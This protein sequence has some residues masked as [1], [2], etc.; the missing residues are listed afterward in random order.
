MGFRQ[1][2]VHLTK[3]M[4]PADSSLSTLHDLLHFI[5][6]ECTFM[7]LEVIQ[8]MQSCPLTSMQLI[9]FHFLRIVGLGLLGFG[10]VSPDTLMRPEL[11]V[12]SSV[13]RAS[14]ESCDRAGVQLLLLL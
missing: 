14:V 2:Q 12:K 5:R 6:A 11:V 3:M 1:R 10:L 13:F 8:R 7:V 4:P 9:K